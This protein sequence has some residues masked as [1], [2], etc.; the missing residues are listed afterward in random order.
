MAKTL[1]QLL[2]GEDME[3]GENFCDSVYNA[4]KNHFY[5]AAAPG[6]PENGTMYLADDGF[7]YIYFDAVWYKLVGATGAAWSK[8]IGATGDYAT[9]AAMIAEM[10]DMIAHATTVEIE[11][12]TTLTEVCDIR[13]KHGLVGAAII[14]VQ[15]EDYFP[16]AGA[17]PTA[18]GGTGTTLVDVGQAWAIDRWID[19]WAFIVDGTGT[20]NGFVK[21]TDSDGTS[22]TVAAWPGAQPDNTSRYLIVGALIEGGGAINNG[23][24]FYNNSV[25]IVLRGIGIN[26]HNEEALR[27]ERNYHLE[28]EYCGIYGA[29]R[30]GIY[31]AYNIFVEYQYLGVVNC[32]T[33]NNANSAGILVISTANA[34]IWYSG[35]SDNNRRGI[36]VREGAFAFVFDCF[37]DLNGQWGT[38]AEYSGQA[39]VGGGECSGAGGNHSDPGTA[40]AAA[41]DQAAVY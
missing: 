41:S 18:T 15:A 23:L 34:R 28:A 11:L 16:Q 5:G 29:D 38:Y 3:G 20:D 22:I 25:P 33:D 1:A 35:L 2:A 39:R 27:L 7:T 6:S 12:G 9:W 4:L 26:D 37:G 40:G 30:D 19:C 8:T 17:I 31:L 21:I 24:Q 32:N 13:N 10:P 36:L 14:N